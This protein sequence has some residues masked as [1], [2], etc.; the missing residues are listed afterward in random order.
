VGAP[1]QGTAAPP[2]L[3]DMIPSQA[4][5][6]EFP[7]I[8]QLSSGEQRFER[9]RR[10]LG[11]L[12]APALFGFILLLDLPALSPEAHRLAAVLAAVIALWVT[13]AVP[14]P[15]SALAGAA[16]CIVLRVAP[17]REVFG[18]FADPLIFLFIGSFILARAIFVHH[19]D[20]RLAFA[21]LSLR[22]VGSSP[23]RILLA[24]GA[25]TAF[26]S[27]WISNTATTAM[28][29]A[30]GM[31]ILAFLFDAERP[32]AR[33]APRF[34]TG[35]M[36]MTSFAATIGGLM[37]PI[38]T[39]PNIIGI[40]F[41]RSLTGAEMPFFRWMSIG[42][43]VALVLFLYTFWY[44]N[45]LC[46][47]GVPRLEGTGEML[48]RRHAALGPWTRGQKSTV[49]AFAVTVTLWIVPGLA[50]LFAG[51]ESA[52]YRELA[53]RMPEAV[54]ALLGAMLLFVLPGTGKGERALTWEQAV[55]I[56]W[57][58]VLLFGGG[59]ALG[60]LSFHSGL[61]E[62]VGR[63]LTE[64]VPVSGPLGLL[65]AATAVAALVSE[66][67]SNTA[68]ANMVVPVVIAIAYAAGV[69]PVPP[70]IGATL[71]AS[72]GFMLPVSTPTN[73]IVYGSGYIP[74]G[75]MIRYGVLLDIGGVIV[76]VVMVSL[77][78]RWLL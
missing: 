76:I 3:R 40:G 42:A 34:A 51:V 55:R 23:A 66:T 71:G 10:R 20:R 39:P 60:T 28:M 62:A 35:L 13:E 78:S 73:A 47:A 61:A 74:L 21:V 30:I 72:M 64:M 32:G 43:P 38:G 67:T 18:P 27:A 15:V 1:Q 29:F 75:R 52:L 5:G 17:A 70:A 44:M 36:L 8:E 57:G 77:L 22:W 11:L 16:A 41:L 25:V 7:A 46:S 14:L 6:A 24:F 63:G 4:V 12:L 19:L 50:A 33:V 9:A 53:Q 45:R 69:D 54:A 65:I 26:S 68:S 37:T 56:D 31:S 58:V 49:A 59:V 2:F 48:R